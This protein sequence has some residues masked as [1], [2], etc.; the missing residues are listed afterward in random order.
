MRIIKFRVW[1]EKEEKMFEHFKGARIDYALKYWET[2]HHVS[3]PMQFTGLTD[4]NGKEIY[5]GD[6]VKMASYDMGGTGVIVFHGGEYA[7]EKSDFYF[8]KINNNWQKIDTASDLEKTFAETIHRH[9]RL[10][11]KENK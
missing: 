5:E 6:I 4:K 7:L 8:K 11:I 3:E 9:I 1:N 2:N 10:Y